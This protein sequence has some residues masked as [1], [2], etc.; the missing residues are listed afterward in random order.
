MKG[1]IFITLAS[2][3]TVY[4][5]IF[6]MTTASPWWVNKPQVPQELLNK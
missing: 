1:I 5:T 4:A 2:F 3:V 6:V